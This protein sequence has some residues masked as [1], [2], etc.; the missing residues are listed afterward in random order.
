MFIFN[1]FLSS[2]YC[3]SF[4]WDIYFPFFRSL[5]K[6][7]PITGVWWLPRIQECDWIKLHGA[8][9][10]TGLKDRQLPASASTLHPSTAPRTVYT[11]RLMGCTGPRW[12]RD[13]TLECFRHK[14]KM[15]SELDEVKSALGQSDV[16]FIL[17]G[18]ISS[19][20]VGFSEISEAGGFIP[21]LSMRLHSL[22]LILLV[23]FCIF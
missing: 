7:G 1:D 9:E 20:C 3:F 19:N 21:P 8:V 18:D 4:F 5:C 11:P 6:M 12:G 2:I 14:W 23:F 17:L 15:R 16:N 13:C 22:N 10:V